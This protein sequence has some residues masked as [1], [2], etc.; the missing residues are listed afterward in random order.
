MILSHD[1][2]SDLGCLFSV[3]REYK[4]YSWVKWGRN[5]CPHAQII[6][7]DCEE[8]TPE[9]RTRRLAEGHWCMLPG[10][11]ADTR[12]LTLAREVRALRLHVFIFESHRSLWFDDVNSFNGRRTW[13]VLTCRL[14]TALFLW[15]VRAVWSPSWPVIMLVA[16]GFCFFF[17]WRV[18]D[19]CGLIYWLFHCKF[20]HCFKI[21]SIL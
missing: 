6:S 19:F 11:F 1:H 5:L 20:C 16:G 8:G 18:F 21:F 17:Y 13:T 7:S 2:F 4:H 9:P 10:C 15:R 3:L 14:R 12:P